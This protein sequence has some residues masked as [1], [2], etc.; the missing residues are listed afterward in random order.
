MTKLADTDSADRAQL[1]RVVVFFGPACFTM[2][3]FAWYFCR[4]KGWIPGWLFVLL[5][6]LNIPLTIAG[7]FAIHH[8]VGA[9]ST[10]LVKT[11]F[12]AGDIAPPPTYPRQEVLI[13]RGQY[14]EAA[15]CFR[16]H[17][18]VEPGDHE[19]RLRLAHLLERHLREYDEVERLYLE[20]RRAEP[21][22]AADGKQLLRAA[23]GLIDLYRRLGRT[24]RLMVELARFADCYRGTPLAD[25]AARELRELKAAALTNESPRS[26]T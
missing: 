15:E 25:G 9:A 22:A 19:A 5:I 12:A 8:A 3:S 26:P 21:P 17:L 23:N 6:L 20:I 1:L 18:Q 7:I 11:I 10:G 4:E 14:A 13:V 24:D 2:L 16:D